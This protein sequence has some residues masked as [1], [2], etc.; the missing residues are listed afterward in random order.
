MAWA[1][2]ELGVDEDT[3][4]IGVSDSLASASG[5]QPCAVYGRLRETAIVLK[6][7]EGLHLAALRQ[8]ISEFAQN[9]EPLIKEQVATITEAITNN[10]KSDP[11]CVLAQ[12]YLDALAGYIDILRSELEFSDSESMQIAMDNYIDPLV[13][14]TNVTVTTFVSAKLINLLGGRLVIQTSGG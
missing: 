9:D 13:E 7:D 6:D 4:E 10:I 12:E 1:A 3:M 8:I 14:N 11:R 5:I 2:E